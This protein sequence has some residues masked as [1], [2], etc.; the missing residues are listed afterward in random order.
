MSL[1]TSSNGHLFGDTTRR[2][3]CGTS[4]EDTVTGNQQYRI[5]AIDA[6]GNTSS[7]TPL[8][9]ASARAT[10]APELL[11]VTS[12]RSGTV[13][14]WRAPPRTARIAVNRYDDSLATPLT[15]ALLPGT[16]AATLI[17]LLVQHEPLTKLLRLTAAATGASR[18]SAALL[19]LCTGVAG[20]Q[21]SIL[22]SIAMASSFCTGPPHIKA[23]FFSSEARAGARRSS[24]LRASTLKRNIS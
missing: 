21:Y 13:L 20:R 14:V 1:A 17:A 19:L 16:T 15:I 23:N 22:R 8:M 24:S 9:A 7:V 2:F 6:H 10:A 4:Y 5:R 3:I 12:T 18:L 11:S